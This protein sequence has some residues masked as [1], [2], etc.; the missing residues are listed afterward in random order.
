MFHLRLSTIESTFTGWD[1]RDAG[2]HEVNT[3]TVRSANIFRVI[4]KLE[5]LGVDSDI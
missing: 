1:N 2:D 4:E 3:G 5:R